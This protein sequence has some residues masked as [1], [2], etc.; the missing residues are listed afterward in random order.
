MKGPAST[1]I[2]ACAVNTSPPANQSRSLMRRCFYLLW[3]FKLCSNGSR[4]G[5]I[6]VWPAGLNW[7][8]RAETDLFNCQCTLANAAWPSWLHHELAPFFSRMQRDGLSYHN[9]IEGIYPL[10]RGD[11]KTLYFSANRYY[12][13]NVLV[14]ISVFF[15]LSHL[16]HWLCTVKIFHRTIDSFSKVA[17]SLALSP[18]YGEGV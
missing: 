2:P 13:S 6:R 7:H 11:N 8:F 1:Y 10:G 15:S 9:W 4:R 12:Y 5:W 16:F 18:G 14:I 3:V 17:D